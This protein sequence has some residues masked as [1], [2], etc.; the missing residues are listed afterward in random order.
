MGI[1]EVELENP[2]KRGDNAKPMIL[3]GTIHTRDYESKTDER[4]ITAKEKKPKQV[5]QVGIRKLYF[6]VYI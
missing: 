5:D 3:A 1:R 6:S 2:I 4:K